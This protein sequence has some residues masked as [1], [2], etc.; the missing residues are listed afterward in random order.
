MALMRA[1]TVGMV[2]RR[3]IYVSRSLIDA[4][5]SEV[6]AIT[7]R[8]IK[9][10]ESVGITGMLWA[11]AGYFAQVLE[12]SP[13]QVGATMERIRYDRRH[14]DV[15]VL[16]DRDVC[17]RQFGNWS[18]IQADDGPAT[19]FMIGFALSQRSEGA[20]RLYEIVLASVR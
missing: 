4:T 11:G 14:T 9:R 18:M 10:N 20:R 7:S 16:L 19:A 12:G 13:D 15:H 5:I 3:L 17:S 8:S 1:P 6:R 2:M